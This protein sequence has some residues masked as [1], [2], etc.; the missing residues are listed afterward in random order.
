MNIEAQLKEIIKFIGDDPTREGLIE[1]PKRIINS[2]KE[3]FSGY[4]T[5]EKDI[6]KVFKDGSCEEMVVLKDIDFFSTCEHHFLPFFGK[7]HIGYI[8]DGKVIGVSKL[9][10]LVEIF[11]RRLQIQEKLTTQIAESLMKNLKPKGVIVVCEAQHLCMIAR[12]I[13]KANSKMVT[14]AVRGAFKSNKTRSEFFQ[15]IKRQ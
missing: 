1:T 11:A 4:N 2:W 3:L 5:K 8:P 15:F 12:G 9:A 6:F 14:S 13:K 7:I 10:R